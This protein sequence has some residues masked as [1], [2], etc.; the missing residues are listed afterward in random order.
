MA[1][2]KPYTLQ[3]ADGGNYP[4]LATLLSATMGDVVD[5]IGPYALGSLAFTVVSIPTV[6]VAIFGGYFL[7]FVVYAVGAVVSI[8]VGDA[9]GGDAGE[10]IVG[11]G[12]IASLLLGMAAMFLAIM[13]A[14]AIIAPVMAGYQRGIARH[15]RGD[16]PM[17]FMTPFQLASTDAVSVISTGFIVATL[18]LIG[19]MF[20][21]VGIIPVIYACFFAAP[22]VSLHRMG[23][24]AAI[25][26]SAK[27]AFGNVGWAL[28]TMLV[29]MIVGML[30]GYVPVLGTAFNVALHVRIHREVFGDGEEPVVL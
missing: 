5:H 20:C 26:T 4:D 8:G 24:I 2:E 16:G 15:Q 25:T 3:K 18:S 6:F 21:Y 29:T 13:G 7:F 14:G 11:L 23:P 10:A 22:L 30:A 17:D 9:V 12:V 19:L 1:A 28:P 27:L